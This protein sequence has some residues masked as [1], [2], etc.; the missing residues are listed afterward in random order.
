MTEC[1]VSQHPD[2]TLLPRLCVCLPPPKHT[3]SL[4]ESRILQVEINTIASS[5]GCLSTR[6]CRLHAYLFHKTLDRLPQPA[7]ALPPNNAIEGLVKG[8][9]VAHFEYL[10]QQ[11]QPEG[12]PAVLMIVQPGERNIM[13]QKTLEVALWDRYKVGE[14]LG[15]F[16]PFMESQAAVGTDF[17]PYPHPCVRSRLSG[18]PFRTCLAEDA[19]PRF[20]GGTWCWTGSRSPSRTSEQG[21]GRATLRTLAIE[22]PYPQN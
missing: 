8:L 2:R 13:D 7:W 4:A 3:Q 20:R 15:P 19:S 10:R 9:A 22:C 14:V 5:F 18:L 11:P 21:E 1:S 6:V 12:R 16:F 17:N